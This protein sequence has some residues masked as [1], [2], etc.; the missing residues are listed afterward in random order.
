MLLLFSGVRLT[1]AA[2]FEKG[3]I[4]IIENPSAL[5]IYDKYKQSFSETEKEALPHFLPFYLL[6]YDNSDPILLL[7]KAKLNSSTVYLALDSKGKL[8]RVGNAGTV[9]QLRGYDLFYKKIV[10]E[11]NYKLKFYSFARKKTVVRTLDGKTEVEILARKK[12]DFLIK[13]GNGYGLAKIGKLL[14][15]QKNI[16]EAKPLSREILNK[17]ENY[18]A[19]TNRKLSQIFAALNKKENAE[20]PVPFFKKKNDY[21]Y[22]F[23]NAELKNFPRTKKYLL[24]KINLLLL[25]E[26][27]KAIEKNNAVLIEKK[28]P[29]SRSSS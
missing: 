19:E 3:T 15:E 16:A 22:V 26:N 2:K 11:K 9:K 10:P 21:E 25:N 14:A 24:D 1:F 28:S 23:K 8:A 7:L 4:L 17:I 6:G 12:N 29:D 5:V 27:Y 13:F 18:F 20:K